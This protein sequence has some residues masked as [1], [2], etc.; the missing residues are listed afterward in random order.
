MWHSRDRQSAMAGNG[1]Q[2]AMASS[3]QCC[4]ILARGMCLAVG[5]A[6]QCLAEQQN[7]NLKYSILGTYNQAPIQC[8]LGLN[9]ARIMACLVS[10]VCVWPMLG[11]VIRLVFVAILAEQQK[12]DIVFTRY[13]FD[14]CQ[15]W[16]GFYQ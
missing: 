2:S 12:N 10:L 1:W 16:G 3:R 13:R 11:I 15:A 8:D 5:N 6:A 7:A 14:D 4:A 9:L